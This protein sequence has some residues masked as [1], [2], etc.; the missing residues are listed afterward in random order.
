LILVD[1][2]ETRPAPRRIRV[3][4]GI[5]QRVS[6]RTGL[7]VPEKFEFTYRDATRR[8]IWQ[9]A[10]G[11][12]K[13]DAQAE[14]MEIVSRMRL[15]QRVERTRST[16]GEVA[17]QWLDRGTGPKGVWEPVTHERYEQ[18]VRVYFGASPDPTQRPLGDTKLRDLTVDRVAQWSRANERVL[19]PT[20]AALTLMVLNQVCRYALRRG[21]LA[22][23][24]VGRLE[25]GERPRGKAQPVAILEGA[26]LT[27]VLE[28]SG[29]HRPLFE[30]LAYTGLRIGEALGLCWGDVDFDAGLVHV[31][32]QLGRD[33][34]PKQLKTDAG[35]RDVILA[36]PVAVILHD[37]RDTS[38]HREPEDLV[39]CEPDGRGLDYQKVG[40]AF[41]AAV[42]AAGI[43]GRGRLSLHS[44][45]HTFA[46]MLIAAGLNVV[47]VSRQLGHAKP[48]TT[49][50]VY[51]HLF[52]QAEHAD[53]ARAALEASYG[54]ATAGFNR[55][56]GALVEP[57]A[58]ETAM[59]IDCCTRSSEPV[60]LSRSAEQPN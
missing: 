37:R 32:Q 46:S 43:T 51:A 7:P 33:G 56:P 8:Q 6:P 1:D 47:F 44:L 28:H 29:G 26:D 41:R 17:R 9:T 30:F 42:R 60:P 45:R 31:R 25:A 15:G 10:K 54:R 40:K 57:G 58:V 5:Y 18:I 23:N 19:A 27:G 38:A 12:T 3:A 16:V 49:L 55:S 35:N 4:E 59:E 50:A 13:A 2:Q 48:T 11:T 53:T 34:E 36:T 20:T 52:A 22:D 24:P 14:R 21:W 39:F